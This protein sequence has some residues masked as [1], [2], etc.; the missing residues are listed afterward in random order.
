MPRSAGRRQRGMWRAAACSPLLP[1][2]G[3][4]DVLWEGN[5][6]FGIRLRPAERDYGRDTKAGYIRRA[7][8]RPAR[9]GVS[10]EEQ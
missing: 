1:R 7:A 8:S 10:I 9:D 5:P 6:A 2:V 4:P 3:F